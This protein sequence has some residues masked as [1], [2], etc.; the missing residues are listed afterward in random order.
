[1]RILL[2]GAT[3][4]I[5]RPLVPAL[6]AAGHEV[7]GLTRAEDRARALDALGA[8]GVVGDA[9]EPGDVRRAADAARPELV[10][11]QLTAFPQQLSKK[12]MSDGYRQTARLR[13]HGTH[14]LIAA[15]PGA[16]VIAQSIAF[17]AKPEGDWVKDEDAPLHTADPGIRA[18][19]EME[20]EV[21]AAGGIVL[22]YGYFYGPGTWYS[23]DGD[24]ARLAR[25]RLL[26]I[27]GAGDA[28]GSFI[29]VDDAVSATLAAVAGGP[30]GVYHVTDDH[31]APQR[32]WLPAFAAAVGARRPRKVPA[33]AVRLAAGPA[34][35]F[36]L[37]TRGADN[38]RFKR[39]FGWEP[40]R[41]DW[42]QGF[43]TL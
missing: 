41:P 10:M 32:E 39:A 34:A 42:R 4:A 6:L 23:A 38:A 11:Q 27:S 30:A 2:A 18:L 7:W 3:G 14:N 33:W 40:R 16:R 37:E 17:A 21:L 25:R 1:V 5:G 43:A 36:L 26:T 9:L 22:R 28:T 19:A 15:A 20:D 12:S 35:F 13:L 31:P 8:H 24:Y 29:H